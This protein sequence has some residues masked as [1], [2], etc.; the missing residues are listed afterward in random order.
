MRF[1]WVVLVLACEKHATEPTMTFDPPAPSS[2]SPAP[3]A[4]AP[5]QHC[6]D[7]CNKTPFP[8]CRFCRSHQIGVR[9]EH[10]EQVGRA[11]DEL[12]QSHYDRCLAT[13]SDAGP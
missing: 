8:D 1:A 2:A 13:C 10:F 9:P 12:C 6:V 3:T 5:S 7:V 11:C 4:S